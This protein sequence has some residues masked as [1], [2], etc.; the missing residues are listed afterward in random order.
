MERRR[1]LLLNAAVHRI[2]PLLF[3]LGPLVLLLSLAEVTARVLDGTSSSAS[4][5]THNSENAQQLVSH[6]T[7][8]WGLSSGQR[9][10]FGEPYSVG[11]D[12]LREV[13]VSG[14]EHRV[15]TLGDSSIF[16]HGLSDD[17]TLHS[18]IRAAFSGR[19]Y[20]VDVFCGGVPGYSTEQSLLLLEEV[21]W[22][23]GPDLLVIGNLWSD[24]NYDYFVDKEW[25]EELASP[26]RVL[27][28]LL[29]W[30]RLWTVVRGSRQP[31]KATADGRLPVGWVKTPY[32]SNDDRHRVPLED[33]RANLKALLSQS[34]RRGVEVI[35]LAPSNRWLLS[36]GSETGEVWAPYFEAMAEVADVEGAPVV[37]ATQHLMAAGLSAD[38]AFLDEMHPTRV[39]N[40]VYAA[41]IVDASLTLGWPE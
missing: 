31:E 41:A 12:G 14:A 28:R 10:A 23:L 30:S 19:G 18:Q 36:R 6:P 35:F 26:V 20:E 38:D 21:G 2:K 17:D 11:E 8:I 7:R 3:S 13:E 1:R 22:S 15:L 39:S 32:A 5:T 34:E 25:L 37:D 40:S 24:Y 9:R 4:E 29:W 33:Y 27:D 16:G